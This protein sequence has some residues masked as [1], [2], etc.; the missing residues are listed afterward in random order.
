MIGLL[1]IMGIVAVWLTVHGIRRRGETPW[2]AEST[3][4][5]AGSTGGG[6]G[7]GGG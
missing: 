5:G 1:V 3:G 4:H 6:G 7:C 2:G